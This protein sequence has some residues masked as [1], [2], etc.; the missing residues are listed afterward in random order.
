MEIKL[1]SIFY[2][3]K[4]NYFT[5]FAEQFNAGIPFWL[6]S[7]LIWKWTW[8]EPIPFGRFATLDLHPRRKLIRNWFLIHEILMKV[9]FTPCFSN[10]T[11]QELTREKVTLLIKDCSSKA[12]QRGCIRSN[13]L[14]REIRR[15][16]E[17]HYRIERSTWTTTNAG[18]TSRKAHSIAVRIEHQ[19]HELHVL[20]HHMMIIF[21]INSNK[22]INCSEFSIIS[23]MIYK[24]HFWF[25]SHSFS[26]ISHHYWLNLSCFYIFLCF[27]IFFIYSFNSS[28]S[29]IFF[30]FFSW[31]LAM[32]SIFDKM[33]IKLIIF[34]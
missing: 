25:I 17:T 12:C 4:G 10:L 20:L 5:P 32:I 23:Y 6:L 24:D 18:P 1:R 19:E 14:W 21:S 9:P 15:I 27:T 30:V 29:S 7:F 22:S 2:S 28:S 3:Q 33:L 34:N 16:S 26:I 11:K 31:N 8:I 13:Y